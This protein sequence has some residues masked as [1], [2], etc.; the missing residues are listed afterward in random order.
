M[1][2]LLD[3][4]KPR[5]AEL[6]RIVLDR[7]GLAPNASGHFRLRESERTP[8]CHIVPDQIHYYDFGSGDSGDALDLIAH[9][10]DLD[11]DFQATAVHDI[12]ASLLGIAKD[13]NGQYPPPPVSNARKA[14]RVKD[15]KDG[16]PPKPPRVPEVGPDTP[17]LEIGRQYG[18]RWS[19]F[20]ARGVRQSKGWFKNLKDH[21]T[22]N[23]EQQALAY[24]MRLH[25]Q[26]DPV[27]KLKS[28]RR[29]DGKRL[30]RGEKSG[31]GFEKGFFDCGLDECHGQPLVLTE[32][33]EKAMAAAKAGFS[34]V[35]I[36]SASALCDDH[37]A[38][39][40]DAGPSEVILAFDNDDAGEKGISGCL[41]AFA[42]CHVACR[43]VDW[44]PDT[45]KKYDLNDV[46]LKS[47]PSSLNKL[48]NSAVAPHIWA[49]RHAVPDPSAPTLPSS[50]HEVWPPITPLGGE[51]PELPPEC[52][53]A[54]D[55]D[56]R[57][58]LSTL[59]EC[60]QVPLEGV[61]PMALAAVSA[62]AMG[63]YHV[64]AYKSREPETPCLYHV[65]VMAPGGGKSVA[66]RFLSAPV[67]EHASQCLKWAW[68]RHAHASAEFAV[69][70]SQKKK[71]LKAATDGDAG[72][73][74][75]YKRLNEKA[76][77]ILLIKPEEFLVT[78]VTE[79]ALAK[80][81]AVNEGRAAIMNDETGAFDG[82]LNI[83]SDKHNV[84]DVY[85]K[86]WDGGR[87]SV[88][89]MGR[90]PIV[91]KECRLVISVCTQPDV[92]SKLLADNPQLAHSGFLSR[93]LVSFI[94]KNPSDFEADLDLLPQ[95]PPIFREKWTSRL[96][97]IAD[98]YSQ[99][100]DCPVIQ[101]YHHESK[102]HFTALTREINKLRD[103]YSP[104]AHAVSVLARPGHHAARIAALLH[105][106]AKG[107]DSHNHPVSP[108]TAECGTMIAR[109]SAESWATLLAQKGPGTALPKKIAQ[110]L[111]TEGP[112]TKRE[113]LRKTKATKEEAAHAIETLEEHNMARVERQEQQGP[114]RPKETLNPHPELQKWLQ[115]QG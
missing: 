48:L 12:A 18:L 76:S 24:P 45:P 86:G 11:P 103:P 111:T 115:Q 26:P 49:E 51:M 69:L 58:I 47:G 40:R 2:T 27:W 52:L 77:S 38:M 10:E 84:G 98:Y 104:Y 62:M 87:I 93:C 60:S 41:G 31:S 9:L 43:V 82:I 107:P 42:A 99:F 23:R 14:A 109:Y 92:F 17:C 34:A 30:T 32:G 56:M 7:Y 83:Y 110:I 6:L 63:G 54:L 44:E 20:T 85:N 61:V 50:V 5:R 106:L 21:P 97:S 101:S 89:R 55:V 8:S 39:I 16:A 46:L 80:V 79:Q 67:A 33:E 78:D 66:Y 94:G 102:A 25:G 64:R 81:M 113:L 57:D 65:L 4:I 13:A 22:E 105:L 36:G 59:C 114:G 112:T 1:T 29:V 96:L 70:E 15:G 3:R 68:T 28:N 90:E 73:M 88:S 100:T 53:T 19:E 35:S 91:I 108:L 37:I 71:A 72:A 75:E 95:M 74:E